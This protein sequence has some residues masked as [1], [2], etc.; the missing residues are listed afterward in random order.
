M[1]WV[2]PGSIRSGLTFPPGGE[3][4]GFRSPPGADL[5][6]ARTE[7][8]DMIILATVLLGPGTEASVADAIA[9]AATHV[10]G[11]ILIES[12]GGDT[13]LK[14]AVDA[15]AAAN[16]PATIRELSWPGDYGA[17]RQQALLFARHIDG[18]CDYAVTLDPDER[19]L[20]TDTF[21]AHLEAYPHVDVWNVQ[22]RDEKYFKERV[23]RCA[24][25][26]RWHG[27]VSENVRGSK[28]DGKLPGQFWE[29][30]KS[31]E[32]HRRRF[33]RGV[34]ECQRMIDE[35]DNCFK[36]HRHRG[37]CLAGVGR[38]DEALAEYWTAHGMAVFA[39]EKAW[40][41]YLICEQLV[42]REQ[43]EEA[44]KMAADALAHHAGYIPEFGWI[45]GYIEYLVGDDQNAS[46]W[47]Q[48]ALHCPPDKTRVSLRGVHCI[49]GCKNLL[50]SLHGQPPPNSVRIH[51]ATVPVGEHVTPTIARA[52]ESG[53]Y[54]ADEY[55]AL[56]KILRKTDR[57]LELGSG[58]GLLAT[59]CAKR[60]EDN[61]R[62][63]TVE[64]DP[65]MADVIRATFVANDV[66]PE[67]LIAAV[68]GSGK[69]MKLERSENFWSTKTS[70][71]LEGV[72]TVDG[73]ALST[74]IERH[75]P[76]ILICDIEG[77]ETTLTETAIEGVRAVLIEVHSEEADK[78]VET[79]LV[80]QG[81][82]RHDTA[83]RVRMYERTLSV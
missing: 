36:W 63:L 47:A 14:A 52:L 15:T 39:E 9:S 51:H 45:L 76:T 3:S 46:R 77:G 43:F 22:E 59:Y 67:L 24:A 70:P 33:E 21:R 17:A 37:S 11:F 83:R 48:L 26:V 6:K 65:K 25:D 34:V 66:S 55:Q 60:L 82:K 31:P 50:H 23:I 58:L 38:L 73:V 41:A 16:K 79:W 56:K 53:S 69:P 2:Q 49:D 71:A 20:L 68:S 80:S 78:A 10:D 7:K 4:Y 28:F 42:L 29:L 75:R 5:L 30:P 8:P 62:V 64:A 19:L 18:G 13:A 12:G 54:E 81:F 72:E 74:L 32:A 35:G 40:S 57:V 1:H 27:R 44:W 61:S